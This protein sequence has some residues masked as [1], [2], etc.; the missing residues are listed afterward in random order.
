MK[1]NHLERVENT[2]FLKSKLQ[3][4]ATS[5]VS[6]SEILEGCTPTIQLKDPMVGFVLFLL[7]VNP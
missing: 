4:L 1:S 6:Y 2:S 7:G 3:D 5:K